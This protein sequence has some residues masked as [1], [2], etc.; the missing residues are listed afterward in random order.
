MGRKEK[1]SGNKLGCDE[2]CGCRT[3]VNGCSEGVK[4]TGNVQIGFFGPDHWLSSVAQLWLFWNDRSTPIA[5]KKPWL[6][7]RLW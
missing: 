4:I 7:L 3:H 6:M 2:T 5:K 1:E